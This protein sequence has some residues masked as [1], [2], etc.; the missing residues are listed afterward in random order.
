MPS[1]D[2]RRSSVLSLFH[3]ALQRFGDGV[4]KSKCPVC[5]DGVLLVKRDRA[6]LAVTPFDHCVSCGQKVNYLDDLIGGEPVLRTVLLPRRKQD[7]V[8]RRVRLRFDLQNKAGDLFRAG[9]IMEVRRNFGG[10]ELR[11][12]S[13]CEACHHGKFRF[14]KSISETQVELLLQS[15]SKMADSRDPSLVLI[16]VRKIL[17]D[18]LKYHE[19]DG[20]TLP[21]KVIRDALAALGVPEENQP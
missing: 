9:E 10:L 1:Q 20:N 14:I 3:S 13:N 12:L 7:W 21:K 15:F 16:S 18:G 2:N 4:F 11:S 8:G 6:S 17:T 19:H 5:D